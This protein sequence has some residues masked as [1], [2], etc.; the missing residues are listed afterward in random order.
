M[1][2]L[3]IATGA[4]FLLCMIIGFKRGF[5]KIV[6]SLVVTIAT[7]VLVIFLSPYVSDFLIKNTPIEETVQKK[8]GSLFSSDD[9]MLEE[10]ITREEQIA[11][12]EESKVPSAFQKMLLDNN[13]SEIYEALG[14]KTFG[15]YVCK[16]LAKLLA[17]VL[18]F[19]LTFLILTILSRIVL[20]LL[21]IIEKLPII[22]GAN[23]AAGGALGIASG[24]I[25]VW[26]LFLVLTLFCQTTWA[27]ACFNNIEESRI[28]KALYDNNIL[29]KYIG[30]I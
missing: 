11:M 7:V 14:V 26:V 16:Y 25:I 20:K 10:D 8:C 28:L 29:L 19:V 27:Q 9:K 4:I 5:I 13:N 2:G 22:G 24:L 15:E 30:G 6:A 23:K 12:I 17:D 21:K 1:N 18:A 3:L